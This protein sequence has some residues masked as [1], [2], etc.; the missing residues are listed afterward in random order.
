MSR[1]SRFWCLKGEA[2]L[3]ACSRVIHALSPSS[4]VDRPHT[5]PLLLCAPPVVTRR[6]F[7]L[8]LRQGWPCDLLW[9]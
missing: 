8:P 7:H 6:L 3:D 4:S 1:V 5:V 2:S 9:Q